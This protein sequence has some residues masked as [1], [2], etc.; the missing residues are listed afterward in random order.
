MRLLNIQKIFLLGLLVL[1]AGCSKNGQPSSKSTDSKN[2]D[3]KTSTSVDPAVPY[4]Q[5]S[6]GATNGVVMEN[7]LFR[8]MGKC[9]EAQGF[10]LHDNRAAMGNPDTRPMTAVLDEEVGVTTIEWAEKYGYRSS[11]DVLEEKIKTVDNGPAPTNPAYNLALYGPED[12]E[13][14][15]AIDPESGAVIARY[16]VS[17]GCTATAETELYGSPE[18]RREYDVLGSLWGG[19]VDNALTTAKSSKRYTDA[20]VAW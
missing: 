3:S 13:S 7:A 15:D 1:A 2:P 14:R 16:K 19:K 20:T 8:L 9:M 6:N 17:G 4:G 18:K 5:I 12:R 10:T 11:T